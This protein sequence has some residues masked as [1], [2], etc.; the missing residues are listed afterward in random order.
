MGGGSGSGGGGCP[1]RRRQAASRR[2][3]VA[4]RPS[5]PRVTRQRAKG[6]E[7]P[8]CRTDAVEG[9][10]GDASGGGNGGVRGVLVDRHTPD[11]P[12]TGV[13]IQSIF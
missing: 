5:E 4:D 6:P 2:R 9:S 12:A 13:Q 3:L 11:P 1:L 10:C 7:G 8:G